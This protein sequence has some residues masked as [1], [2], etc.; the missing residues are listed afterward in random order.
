MKLIPAK[1]VRFPEPLIVWT[2]VRRDE[3]EIP[4][5]HFWSGWGEFMSNGDRI[6]E[7]NLIFITYEGQEYWATE[8]VHVFTDE[9]GTFLQVKCPGGTGSESTL[10]LEDSFIVEP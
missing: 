4:L 2:K 6:K 1:D 8:L 3:A 5:C 7:T 9:D 10:S